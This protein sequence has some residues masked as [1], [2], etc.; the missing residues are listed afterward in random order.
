MA[1]SNFISLNSSTI[2]DFK[3]NNNFYNDIMISF[4]DEKENIVYAKKGDIVSKDNKYNFK[5]TTVLK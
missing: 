3:K 1:Y 5:L 2:L 4:T